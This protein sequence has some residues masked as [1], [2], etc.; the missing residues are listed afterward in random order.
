MKD[1]KKRQARSVISEILKEKK[2]KE[3][4]NYTFR[5]NL[6]SKKKKIEQNNFH[7]RNKDWAEKKQEKLLEIKKNE[8]NLFIDNHKFQP[9]LVFFVLYL[10]IIY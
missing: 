7:L 2:D 5:P 4:N 8:E 10:K 3:E 9:N 6:I 1:K